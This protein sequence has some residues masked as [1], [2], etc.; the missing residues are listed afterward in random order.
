M[1][2]AALLRVRDGRPEVLTVSPD[3]SLPAGPLEPAHR[4]LQAGMRSWVER[5]TGFKLGHIEQLYTFGDEVTPDQLR[6]LRVSYMALTRESGDQAGWSAWYQHFPWE[7][8]RA[9]TSDDLLRQI[10]QRLT[11]WA[12]DCLSRKERVARH[13]GL[14]GYEWLCER[15]LERYEMMWEAGLL[16]EAPHHSAPLLSG[17]VM[18]GDHRRILATAMGRLRAK[19][20]YTPALF[21]LVPEEFT[22]RSLQEALEAVSGQCLHKQ[23]FRRL[24][25]SQNLII[26]TDKQD[27]GSAGRPA[28]LYR[29]AN[30]EHASCALMGA[31]LPLA[32]LDK[33]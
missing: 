5:Q 7:D 8:R 30:I 11:S 17:Q 24:I 20:R 21:R 23:N 19:C 12:G 3:V 33:A 25:Q 29:L 31:N 32:P 14:N 22:L 27:I 13:F 28:R 18:Q 9:A 15:A 26:E 4:T 16:P 1:L 2:V 6:L 10:V